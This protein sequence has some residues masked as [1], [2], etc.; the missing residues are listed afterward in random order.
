MGNAPSAIFV[1]ERPEL[2]LERVDEHSLHLGVRARQEHIELGLYGDEQ[3]QRLTELLELRLPDL[4]LGEF[5]GRRVAAGL[6]SF[7][8]RTLYF[9]LDD[10]QTL[11]FVIQSKHGSWLGKGR[12]GPKER[13]D[14]RT[15]V[16]R[17]LV[18]S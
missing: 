7:R 13:A 14:W 6:S 16:E 8:Y 15:E 3:L 1:L 11:G 2:E 5:E 10:P 12:L 9:F 4:N 17:V 18:A